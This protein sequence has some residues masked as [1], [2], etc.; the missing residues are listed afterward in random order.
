MRR[1]IAALVILAQLSCAGVR[2]AEVERPKDRDI[3]SL[4]STQLIR[5]GTRYD[6]WSAGFGAGA[7]ASL[8]SAGIFGSIHIASDSPPDGARE[9]A[10]LGLAGG[11]AAA[12]V[13]GF[14]AASAERRWDELEWREA[15]LSVE[16]ASTSTPSSSRFPP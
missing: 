1:L 16:R 7:V 2:G 13:A 5:S 11:V 10:L 3:Q 4:S 12:I 14:T 9:A 15:N 6:F 8:L